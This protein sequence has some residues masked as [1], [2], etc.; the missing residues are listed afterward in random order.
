MT[1]CSAFMSGL[2]TQ[3]GARHIHTRARAR[4]DQARK[5]IYG[6]LYSTY[7]GASHLHMQ[8]FEVCLS[9]RGVLMTAVTVTAST[10]GTG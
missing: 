7:M 10:Q 1:I 8:R 4:E 5:F 2:R 6:C 3:N 9:S